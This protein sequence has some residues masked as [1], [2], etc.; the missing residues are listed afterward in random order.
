MSVSG[1][2]MFTEVSRKGV[3]DNGL[4]YSPLLHFSLNKRCLVFRFHMYGG[5]VGS[6]KVHTSVNVSNTLWNKR[7]RYTLS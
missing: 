6:L 4:L 7:G 5:A 1:Y 3:E 2:Y